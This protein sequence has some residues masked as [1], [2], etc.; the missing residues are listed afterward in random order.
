MI[1]NVSSLSKIRLIKLLL[2]LYKNIEKVL[3]SNSKFYVAY[4][5]SLFKIFSINKLPLLLKEKQCK[6]FFHKGQKMFLNKQSCT[7]IKLLRFK[8]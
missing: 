1:F 3:T 8:S 5:T 2:S 6:S 7:S 4:F